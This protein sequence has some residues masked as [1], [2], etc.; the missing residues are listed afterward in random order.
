MILLEGFVKK[1][2][3]TPER[4]LKLAQARKMESEHDQEE[5]EP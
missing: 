4:N 1:T 2:R 3:K 5:I